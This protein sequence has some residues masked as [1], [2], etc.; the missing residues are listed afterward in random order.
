[1]LLT[2]HKAHQRQTESEALPPFTRRNEYTT[3]SKAVHALSQ[4]WPKFKP[5]FYLEAK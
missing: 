5:K 2:A 1:L 4:A 3:A